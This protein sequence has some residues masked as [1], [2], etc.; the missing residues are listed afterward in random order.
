MTQMD[1]NEL[2]NNLPIDIEAL[3]KCAEEQPVL[4]CEAGELA[5]EAKADARRVHAALEQKRAEVDKEV[6]RDPDK[7]GLAK[8]TESSIASAVTLHP[9][10]VEANVKA[11]KADAKVDQ[12]A[13]L[14]DAYQH[15]KSMLQM[16][17][18]LY[19][20]NYFGDVEVKERQMGPT[21]RVAREQT[22][23]VVENMRRKQRKQREAKEAKG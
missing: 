7:Y 4:A 19:I 6:R 3:H 15:R 23:S 18:Q 22:N 1:Y 8:T 21:K 5:A 9:Q 17:A 14:R 12:F 13:A 11:I 20:A 16:E 2:R 10:V